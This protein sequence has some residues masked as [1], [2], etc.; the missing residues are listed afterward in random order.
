M[1]YKGCS[2]HIQ[3]KWGLQAQY[4]SS[5]NALPIYGPLH[6]S[7]FQGSALANNSAGMIFF[8]QGMQGS[9]GLSIKFIKNSLTASVLFADLT[10]NDVL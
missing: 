7:T 8:Y 1:A 6:T 3:V 10:V 4:G 5:A 2:H 9:A